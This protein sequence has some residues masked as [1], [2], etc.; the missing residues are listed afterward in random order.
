MSSI[1]QRKAALGGWRALTIAVGGTALVMLDASMA[2][3]LYPEVLK[4]YP[5]ASQVTLSWFL[6][7][8]AIC[9]A[10]LLV[11]GGRLADHFG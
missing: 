10:A 11:I 1:Q 5:A 8:Y 7:A 9:F 4:T 2:N 3:F 6:T